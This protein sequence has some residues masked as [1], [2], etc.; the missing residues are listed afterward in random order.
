MK[1]FKT[2]LAYAIPIFILSFCFL[3]FVYP[4][5]THTVPTNQL[6]QHSDPELQEQLMQTQSYNLQKTIQQINQ[7]KEIVVLEETGQYTISHDKTKDC[8][9]VQKFLYG[10]DITLNLKYKSIISIPVNKINFSVM[11]DGK[12]IGLR[13]LYNKNYFHILS[14]EIT[15]FTSEEHKSFFGSYYDS[16]EVLAL[17]QVAKT[18]ISNSVM[19][20]KNIEDAE[21]NLRDTIR[22]IAFKSGAKFIQY[23]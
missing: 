8:N 23:E 21:L 14:T 3:R 1:K 6:L 7:T 10:S 2:F 4:M 15:D 5:L 9:S 11:K 12:F 18:N 17:E 20:S 19:T 13:M 16:D 22:D